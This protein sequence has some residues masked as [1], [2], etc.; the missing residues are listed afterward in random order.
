MGSP[1]LP[2]DDSLGDPAQVT[3]EMCNL[4]Q[5]KKSLRFPKEVPKQKILLVPNARREKLRE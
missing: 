1:R 2:T 3:D 5:S 4:S